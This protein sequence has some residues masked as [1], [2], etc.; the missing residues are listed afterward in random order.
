[1]LVAAG[2]DGIDYLIGDDDDLAEQA[3]QVE[4]EDIEINTKS[5]G[6]EQV[7]KFIDRDPG[8]VA[9]LLR[10]WLSDEG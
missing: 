2:A 3:A 7:E 6:L 4:F 8:S 1:M 9:Q 10:N 5:P